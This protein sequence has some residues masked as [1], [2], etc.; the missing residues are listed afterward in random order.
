MK[1][2]N[3]ALLLDLSFEDVIEAVDHK[4]ERDELTSNKDNRNHCSDS[5]MINGAQNLMRENEPT[6]HSTLHRDDLGERIDKILSSGGM[7]AKAIANRLGIPRK[8]VNSYLY[9]H[10][11][12]YERDDSYIPIWTIRR[13]NYV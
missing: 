8:E 9:S 3:S 6:S 1:D 11:F 12:R 4:I 10:R 2:D 7:T 5:K 13:K